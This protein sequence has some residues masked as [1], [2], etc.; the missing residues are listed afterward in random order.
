M[1]GYRQA[2]LSATQYRAAQKSSDPEVKYYLRDRE[3]SATDSREQ[4]LA[5]RA[6]QERIIQ[7]DAISNAAFSFN[8]A[9]IHNPGQ[10]P[11]NYYAGCTYGGAIMTSV[12]HQPHGK[13]Y[14]VTIYDKKYGNWSGKVPWNP[15][16]L[17]FNQEVGQIWLDADGQQ[18][19]TLGVYKGK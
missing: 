5:D 1:S 13:S 11:K 9:V 2:R 14:D 18:K 3:E 12:N 7:R 16:E 17:K 8:S 10:A 6:I 19:V 4:C 15:Q